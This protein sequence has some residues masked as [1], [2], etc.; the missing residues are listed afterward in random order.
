MHHIKVI[1][2]AIQVVG[3]QVL[4]PLYNLAVEFN[5]L[6]CKRQHIRQFVADHV[7]GVVVAVNGSS[8]YIVACFHPCPGHDVMCKLPAEYR[9]T[10]S[11]L[12][13]VLENLKGCPVTHEHHGIHAAV[14]SMAT[15]TVDTLPTPAQTATM[16][17]KSQH[18]ESS[19]LGRVIDA[20]MA[21]DGSYWCVMHADV[22]NLPGLRWLLDA[23]VLGSV[24]LTH[25]V[26][27]DGF[28]HP[29]EMSLVSKPARPMCDIA[30]HTTCA[31]ETSE[32]KARLQVGPHLRASTMEIDAPPLSAEDAM[33]ALLAASPAAGQIIAA[34]FAELQKRVDASKKVAEASTS[35]LDTSRAQLQEA[36]SALKAQTASANVD[37]ALL[38]SQLQQLL[39]NAPLEAQ[40]NCGV[41]NLDQLATD[42][43]STDAQAALGATL[44]TIMCCNQ[45]MMMARLTQPTV[46]PD[47]MHT[48]AEVPQS[49]R[50][51]ATTSSPVLSQAELLRKAL[52]ATFET[53]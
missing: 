49:K 22:S 41:Q 44:R 8:M 27:Q 25:I 40:S 53:V 46:A 7:A 28:P 12:Q 50:Q 38:R 45:T 11:E 24:S 13:C 52:T 47:Q 42:L 51:R 14:D 15:S 33:K 34:R 39:T 31:I 10:H 35:E 37:V 36:E 19:V 9:M 3:L 29:L 4:Q 26:R 23:K 5:R 1:A 18:P 6:N 43:T 16:L 17:H 2:T 21:R 30:L 48:E 32:Y 20:F